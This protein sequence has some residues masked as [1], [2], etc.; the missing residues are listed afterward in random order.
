MNFD[1][2]ETG[3]V[4]HRTATRPVRTLIKN[5]ELALKNLEGSF[6]NSDA[7][8]PGELQL[9][10][11]EELTTKKE[12]QGRRF[13]LRFWK[14]YLSYRQC[15]NIVFWLFGFIGLLGMTVSA[16]MGFGIISGLR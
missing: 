3:P 5:S 8:Q 15:F 13:R 1:E 9:F 6:S 7:Q 14:T 10:R 12:R 11:F 2:I 4:W 16:M